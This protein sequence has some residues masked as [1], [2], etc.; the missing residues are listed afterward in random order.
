MAVCLLLI[1]FS[2]II[3]CHRIAIQFAETK[4]MST[5]LPSP[6]MEALR[7][8]LRSG[9]NAAAAFAAL[10]SAARGS[11]SS[12]AAASARSSSNANADEKPSTSNEDTSNQEDDGDEV[13][14][15]ISYT[16][17][18]PAKLKCKKGVFVVVVCLSL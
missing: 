13:E 11:S 17:Y 16:P 7:D 1:S 18:K 14:D 3:L 8:A 9:S 4:T 15:E 2:H 10:A 12:S 5:S 6:S